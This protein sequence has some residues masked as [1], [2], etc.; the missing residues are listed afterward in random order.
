MLPGD[1][2]KTSA[3]QT[4][5]RLSSMRQTPGFLCVVKVLTACHSQWR[6][7]KFTSRLATRDTAQPGFAPITKETNIQITEMASRL[8]V[9]ERRFVMCW[10][11]HEIVLSPTLLRQMHLVR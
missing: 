6:T 3:Q 7:L 10:G 8:N 1:W 9:Q 2:Y 4:Y 5:D 11:G